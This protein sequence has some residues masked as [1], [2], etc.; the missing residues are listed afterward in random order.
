[1]GNSVQAYRYL[2]HIT[3]KEIAEGRH[4]YSEEY[5]EF[6][7]VNDKPFDYHKAILDSEA[8][9]KVLR[10]KR[11]LIEELLEEILVSNYWAKSELLQK[12]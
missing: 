10:E 7:M 4:I 12:G 3:D 2:L 6:S 11:E 1:M 5:L 9:K 8:E